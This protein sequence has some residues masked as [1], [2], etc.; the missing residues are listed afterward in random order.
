MSRALMVSECKRTLCPEHEE[1]S[2]LGHTMCSRRYA[3]WWDEPQ[4]DSPHFRCWES[5]VRQL[6]EAADAVAEADARQR[7][8]V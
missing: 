2:C 8:A 6:P 7:V 5:E 3:Y 4:T 1:C